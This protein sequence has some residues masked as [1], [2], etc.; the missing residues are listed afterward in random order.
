MA[1]TERFDRALDLA[2]ELHRD[3]LRKGTKIPYVVHLMA[4]ACLVSEN[5]GS[6]EQVI[7]ALLHDA[8]EDQGG[9]PIARRILEAFG[10]GVHSIVMA[11]TDS[12]TATAEEK[13]PWDERK[14]AYLA[15]LEKARA[16]VRLVSAADKLH[17]ARSIN[18][19][20]RA[21]GAAVWKRF[22]AGREGSLWYYRRLVKVFRKGWDHPIVDL[23]AREVREMVRL[24]EARLNAHG[25]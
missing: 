17:N 18:A 16:R 14:R 8:V 12:V 6:E 9:E 11:C 20:L 21:H 7:A 4:V 15:H 19:D 13:K 1:F 2:H 25:R 5:G 3:Q 23:L 10:P 24:S 22:K